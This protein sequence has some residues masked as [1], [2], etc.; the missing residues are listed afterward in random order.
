MY[1]RQVVEYTLD[2]DGFA[3]ID[4][5]W[6]P[7]DFTQ[8]AIVGGE[9]NDDLTGSVKFAKGGVYDIDEDD[10]PIVLF[11]DMDGEEGAVMTDWRTAIE[12]T[13]NTWTNNAVYVEENETN[14][15]VIVVDAGDNDL[16]VSKVYTTS[17][18]EDGLRVAL[19]ADAVSYNNCTP[20]NAKWS[21]IPTKAMVGTEVTVKATKSEGKVWG[22]ATFT[23]TINGTQVTDPV[24]A[25]NGEEELTFKYTV[26]KAD[27]QNGVVAIN[28]T[29]LTKA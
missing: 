3:S 6:E 22:K 25:E 11:V 8:A 5:K 16:S 1:K 14:L 12:S 10:D 21:V 7:K 20:D 28:V 29:A 19:K 2:A 23:A 18:Q 24:E 15:K 17:S 26:K 9:L 4:N 13:P 27:V